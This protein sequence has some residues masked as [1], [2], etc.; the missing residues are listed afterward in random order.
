M[1]VTKV[2]LQRGVIGTSRAL[3][4]LRTN[5]SDHGVGTMLEEAAM[6]KG[7]GVLD[8]DTAGTEERRKGGGGDRG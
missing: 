2:T 5:P 7:G 8:K 1:L 3:F 6:M 4:A